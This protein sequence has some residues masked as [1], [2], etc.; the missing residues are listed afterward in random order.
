MEDSHVTQL[1]PVYAPTSLGFPVRFLAAVALVSLLH[2]YPS[3]SDL[4][5]CAHLCPSTK[6]KVGEESGSPRPSEP[7]TEDST[8]APAPCTGILGVMQLAC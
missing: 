5:A 4:P 6:E 8:G 7:G 1:P 3:L 2:R